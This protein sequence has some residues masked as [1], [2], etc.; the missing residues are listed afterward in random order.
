M[1]AGA[2]TEKNK[3]KHA[4]F[5]MPKKISSLVCSHC[6]CELLVTQYD[7]QG[8]KQMVAPVRGLKIQMKDGGLADVTCPKC[9]KITT[10]NKERV[11]NMQ[12]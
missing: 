1:V 2:L 5:A 9:G 8:R 6:S 7:D 3:L 11:I 4:R 10:F 12:K